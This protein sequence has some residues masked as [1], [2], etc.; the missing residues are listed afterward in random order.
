MA[1]S[2]GKKWISQ[3]TYISKQSKFCLAKST[4]LIRLV[5]TLLSQLLQR[6]GLWLIGYTPGLEVVR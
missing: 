1:L 3:K 5:C 6:K 2:T 4:N